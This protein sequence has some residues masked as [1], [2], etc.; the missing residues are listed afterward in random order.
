ML[1]NPSANQVYRQSTGPLA[2]AELEATTDFARSI[3]ISSIGNAEAVHFSSDEIDEL[4]LAAQS[5]LLV[6]F[7]DCDGLLR[8]LDL[9]DLR[10]MDDDL[11]TI[12]K[13][14]GKTNEAFTR[15]LL[16][17]T[18]AQV[19]RPGPLS[20]L[21]PLAGRGTTLLAAWQA[22]HH[23]YG[24]EADAKAFEAL[25]SYLTTYLRT[26]RIKHSLHVNPVRRD[27]RLIGRK[28]EAEVRLD[29]PTQSL[30]PRP[31]RPQL[32]MTVF[33]GDTRE[34]AALFGRKRFDAI[35]TDSPYGIVHGAEHRRTSGSVRNQSSH[36]HQ[37]APSRDRSPADLLSQAIPVWRSQLKSG[38]ALGISWNTY[39]LPRSEMLA[40]LEQAG[41]HP[42]NDGPWLSFSHRVDA[43]INRDLVVA[44]AA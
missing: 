16:H 9:P 27:G 31:G 4:A 22:G 33:T 13:Y 43:S 10:V 26:K 36:S 21:D 8:P 24:V 39:T 15:L 23:G 14:P 2:C 11:L 20:I 32:Q 1:L 12:P 44:T 7:E 41:F 42:L 18:V 30:P 38:G 28:L 29:Q 3:D 37:P 34:S 19:S 40:M 6:G 25:S 17:L 35:V 5:S